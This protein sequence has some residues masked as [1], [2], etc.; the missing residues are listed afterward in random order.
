MTQLGKGLL[1]FEKGSRF[2]QIYTVNETVHRGFISLFEDNNPLHTNCSYAQ[3]KGFKSE[4]M[5]GNILNGFISHFV[6]ECLPFKNLILQT[7][8]IRFFRPVYLN[9]ILFLKVEVNDYFESVKTAELKFLFQNQHQVI[10]ARG[11]LTIGLI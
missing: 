4:V 3:N 2:E 9:D 8:E 5:H 10:V 1:M 7:Q 6:G 11:K